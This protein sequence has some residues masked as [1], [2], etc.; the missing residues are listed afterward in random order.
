MA[1]IDC[2]ECGKEISDKAP[3]CPNCG[4]VFAKDNASTPPDNN[5]EKPSNGAHETIDKVGAGCVKVGCFLIFAVI[6]YGIAQVVY[7]CSQ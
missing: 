3:S 5:N 6:V 1:L 4:V 7:R 2:P